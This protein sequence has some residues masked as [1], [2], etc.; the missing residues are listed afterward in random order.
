MVVKGRGQNGT[1]VVVTVIH[2]GL[3]VERAELIKLDIALE[4]ME[5]RSTGLT[6]IIGTGEG[7][8]AIGD[9]SEAMIGT[10]APSPEGGVVGAIDPRRLLVKGS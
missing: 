4:S 1:I 5:L 2:G 9:V 10:I 8:I 7:S 6:V 3:E